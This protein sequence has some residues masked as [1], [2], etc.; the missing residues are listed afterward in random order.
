MT[1]EL[2]VYLSNKLK[3]EQEVYLTDLGSGKAKDFADYRFSC[4]V[5]RGLMIAET[6]I[7][8]TSKRM[9]NADE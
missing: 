6:L 5:L 3:E 1:D 4:G 7:N 8:E 2:L 9:E